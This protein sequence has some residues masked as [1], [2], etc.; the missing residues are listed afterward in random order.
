MRIV[1]LGP[2]GSGKGTQAVRL[3]EHYRVQHVSTGDILRDEVARQTELGKQAKS[4][5]DQGEL[6]PDQLVV[7]MVA[8]RLKDSFVLDGFP[9]SLPQAESLDLLL[10]EKNL[11]LTAV[12]NL[13]VPE[14]E[15]V[16]RLTKRLVCLAC[17]A[18]FP[19]GTQGAC[20]K[21]GGKLG[22]RGDDKPETIR[23]RLRVYRQKT[24]PLEDYYHHRQGLL[25]QIPG[26]GAPDEIFKLLTQQLD[27]AK[28]K[29]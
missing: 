20:A 11:P 23:E 9:R 29:N 21:C 4:F 7:D 28:S 14:E 19:S 2:P 5:M 24:K 17:K 3:S 26:M 15:I 8:A 18:V 22:K 16:R 25:R 27:S 12:F 6:V 13:D 1:L 10:K